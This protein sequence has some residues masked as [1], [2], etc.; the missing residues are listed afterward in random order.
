VFLIGNS[1]FFFFNV[2]SVELFLLPWVNL[3]VL[4][5]LVWLLS[6][7]FFMLFVF[8]E[9]ERLIRSENPELKL[10]CLYIVDAVCRNDKV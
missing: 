2:E 5:W 8:V 3:Q 7:F 9:I 1:F 4:L 6:I 10:P